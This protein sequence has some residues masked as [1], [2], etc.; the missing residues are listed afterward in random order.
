[1]IICDYCKKKKKPYYE[2]SNI[3]AD[4]AEKMDNDLEGQYYEVY[5]EFGDYKEW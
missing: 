1:M 5:D 4:C 3:C 2:S